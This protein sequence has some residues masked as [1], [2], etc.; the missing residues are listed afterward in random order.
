MALLQAFD[1]TQGKW[2]MQLAGVVLSAIS[3]FF[4]PVQQFMYTIGI[5]VLADLYTGWRKS[6]KLAEDPKA[7]KFNSTGLGKTLE[8]SLLYLALMAVGLAVDKQAGING[9]LSISHIIGGFV[10]YR[11]TLSNVEN[12]DAIL[13][14][15]LSK[16]IKDKLATLFKK[17]GGSTQDPTV[18]GSQGS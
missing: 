15:N 3:S 9:P 11:E 8:K 5:L 6:K 1:P 7:R 4:L 2:L 17:N 12:F 18:Q 16:L 10:I 13:G 14:T